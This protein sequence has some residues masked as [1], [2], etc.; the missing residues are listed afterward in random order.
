MKRFLR[1]RWFLIA[2][3]SLVGIAL[4]FPGPLAAALQPL[5]PRV[6]IGV[7]LALM[8]WTMPTRT[9]RDEMRSPWG[10]LLAVTVGYLPLPAAGWFLGDLLG[11]PA[12]LRVGFLLACSVPCTLA[13]CI[14][15]TRLAGGNEATALLAVLISTLASPFIVP[16]WLALTL[17][18][19]I[20]LPIPRMMLDLAATVV[21]PVLVGQSVRRRDSARHFA[22][23]H[24]PMLGAIAQIFILATVA[25]A[26]SAMGLRLREEQTL[27][28]AGFVSCAILAAGLHLAALLGGYAVA[29]RIGI[30]R[31]RAIAVGFCGSQKTLPV[32][33]ALFDQYFE[34]DYPLAM[35][36]LVFFHMGQLLLDTLVAERWKQNT[37]PRS[38]P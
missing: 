25:R 36:P 14:L 2:M 29:R 28:I 24:K 27:G 11:P 10:A 37:A 22:D 9:L 16:A 31:A 33:L 35:A 13:S 3:V 1:E 8:A 7:A 15:W 32:S 26:A 18:A 19:S 38:Q 6:V 23:R 17:G 20:E 21:L 4:V 12:D 34:A 5:D 30:D